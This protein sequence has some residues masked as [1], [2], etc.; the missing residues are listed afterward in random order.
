MTR[1]FSRNRD[2]RRKRSPALV[3]ERLQ[4]ATRQKPSGKKNGERTHAWPEGRGVRRCGILRNRRTGEGAVGDS[5]QARRFS[6]PPFRA[7]AQLWSLTRRSP[8]HGARPLPRPCSPVQLADVGLEIPAAPRG[9]AST[10]RPSRRGRDALP[11]G[12]YPTR[13]SPNFF[14]LRYRV[15]R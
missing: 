14:T 8:Q 13:R 5:A 11:P 15:A 7:C 10:W 9:T 2:G 4:D 6:N 3:W 12:H 1:I